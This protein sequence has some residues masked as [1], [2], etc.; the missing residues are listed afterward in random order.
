MTEITKEDILKLILRYAEDHGV[1]YGRA[2]TG[3]SY[4]ELPYDVWLGLASFYK[5]LIKA[6]TSL[7]IYR[8]T[9]TTYTGFFKT[10]KK[11]VLDF[12]I[13]SF[14]LGGRVYGHDGGLH[15]DYPSLIQ[16]LELTE[17]PENWQRLLEKEEQ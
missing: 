17:E 3:G 10:V 14:E 12:Y 16:I 4:A 9:K 13:L 1:Y 15:E 2:Y 11:K 8:R 7:Y 5:K 6:G